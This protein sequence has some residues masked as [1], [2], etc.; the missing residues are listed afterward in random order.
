M[1]KP[2]DIGDGSA[3]ASFVDDSVLA[4]TRPHR[5]EGM[6]ELT[7]AGPFDES[8]RRDPDAVRAY[9]ASLA[10]RDTGFLASSGRIAQAAVDREGGF[11]FTWERPPGGAPVELRFAGRLQ[12]PPYAEITD[13]A[14]LVALPDDTALAVAGHTLMVS[15]A[16]LRTSATLTVQDGTPGRWT[17]R[18]PSTATWDGAGGVADTDLLTVTGTLTTAWDPPH[19]VGPDTVVVPSVLEE[20]E[21]SVTVGTLVD[22]IANYIRQCC[23]LRVGQEEVA[24]VT[25]HRLLPL[26]WTRD[27]Y[28]MALLLLL[29][30]SDDDVRTVER[31]L[32]WMWG[33]SRASGAWMRSHLTNGR[34]K[35]PG[36]Q[37]D[38]QLYPVLELLQ[39]REVAGRWPRPVGRPWGDLVEEALAALPLDPVTGLVESLENPADDPVP[40]PLL[41]STQ[42]L[43]AA[44]LARLLDH[45][46]ELGLPAGPLES[47]AAAVRRGIREVFVVPG[48]PA[49]YAYAADA[50]GGHVLYADANDLPTALAPAWGVISADDPVWRAT[51][52]FAFSPANPG[53]VAGLLGGLG[54]AHTP[55]AWPLGDVQELVAAHAIGD[56]RRARRVMSKL[57]SIAA[58]DG[59]LPEAYDVAT[60]DWTARHWFG[61]PAA[62]LA[63]AVLSGGTLTTPRPGRG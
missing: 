54:S 48:E 25:D 8:S 49:L 28:Y 16:S 43:Y 60:G 27:A 36:L 13:I 35:D 53:W 61:W 30:A 6:V 47:R 40:Y 4:I 14:P 55:G 34:V 33:P 29:L 26:S 45:A 23:G 10:Q 57:L 41:F 46:D 44:T 12:R 52:R 50:A 39:F 1:R 17:V 63:S 42:V 56:E 18:G 24:I 19:E 11:R 31:H 58:R 20:R 32:R 37:G 3:C 62:A 21:E 9:R 7:G 51:M 59:H 5:D 38:Q 2:Y 22:G 15:S